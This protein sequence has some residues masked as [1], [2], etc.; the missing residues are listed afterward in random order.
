MMLLVLLRTCDSPLVHVA[1][2]PDLHQCEPV[3]PALQC[4]PVN[5]AL[6]AAV[7]APEFWA[8]SLSV[9]SH[10]APTLRGTTLHPH[11]PRPLMSLVPLP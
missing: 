11:I 8:A 2:S 5:P 9:L 4:E 7:M 1:S 10:S 6:L 3:N